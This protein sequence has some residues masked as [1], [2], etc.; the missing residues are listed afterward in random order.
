MLWPGYILGVAWKS[1]L[2]NIYLKLTQNLNFKNWNFDL[3]MVYIRALRTCISAVCLWLIATSS[4]YIHLKP[5]VLN[6]NLEHTSLAWKVLRIEPNSMV[7]DETTFIEKTR[8]KTQLFRKSK[9]C[10]FFPINIYVLRCG[11]CWK[12]SNWINTKGS[13]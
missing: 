10:N 6:T 13:I 2:Q 4:T 11:K 5:S 1:W 7:L 12:G 8:R 9:Y 3:G